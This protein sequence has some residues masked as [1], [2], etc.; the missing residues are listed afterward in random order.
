MFVWPAPISVALSWSMAATR[1]W[2]NL[3]PINTILP[4]IIAAGCPGWYIM[5]CSLGGAAFSGT[6]GA[7][8][9]EMVTATSVAAAATGA[10]A[11]GLE[12]DDECA[13][14]DVPN[15]AAGEGLG[16]TV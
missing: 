1:H 15:V 7:L 6:T 9:G 2:P 14:T 10:D 3:S 8:V 5:P 11:T 4:L 12:A 13:S 16:G